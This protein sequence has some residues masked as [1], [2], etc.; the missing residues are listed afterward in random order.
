MIFNI[1]LPKGCKY[2]AVF[3]VMSVIMLLAGC[4][5]K[6][7]LAVKDL[8]TYIANGDYDK[9]LEKANELIKTYPK[10]Q[11][12]LRN[13]GLALMGS[14]DFDGA[15]E[16]FD[17]AL[18]LNKN[19]IGTLEND[20]IYYKAVALNRQGRDKQAYDEISKLTEKNKKYEAY[21][22]QG[23]IALELGRKQDAINAFDKAVEKNEKDY[24]MYI[25]LYN[26]M[27][28]HS[29]TQTGKDYLLKGIKLAQKSNDKFFLGKLY[30]YNKEYE[31]AV[32]ALEQ[33]SKNSEALV[34]LA[35][36]LYMQGD[37]EGAFNISDTAINNGD[38]FGEHYNIVGLY[39]LS[40]NDYKNALNSFDEGLKLE[41]IKNFSELS[42]N[43]AVAYEFMG[44]FDSAK[45]I[46][47]SLVEE[48]PDLNAAKREF[49]FLKTR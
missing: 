25:E 12:I 2:M 41:N 31:L 15:I 40:R 37:L 18:K 42:Y 29:Y 39:Y 33:V 26:A 30:Y 36:A 14:G 46:M 5:S 32:K 35:K 9:A 8:D 4:K 44:D 43:K 22:L 16:A 20:I 28:T 24:D 13:M 47:K 10:N 17:N 6:Q 45:A 38:I 48:Y 27:D 19:I 49:L 23:M 34:Y 11:F 3:L 1:N 7:A 21:L